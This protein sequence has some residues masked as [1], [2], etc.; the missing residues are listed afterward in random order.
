MK[1]DDVHERTVTAEC[2]QWGA[3]EAGW[4]SRQGDSPRAVWAQS[5]VTSWEIRGATNGFSAPEVKVKSLL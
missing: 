3:R 4:R 1:R 5:L 2:G